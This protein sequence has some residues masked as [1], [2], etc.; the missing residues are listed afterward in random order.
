M[1]ARSSNYHITGVTVCRGLNRHPLATCGRSLRCLRAL[2]ACGLILWEDTDPFFIH[3]LKG[4]CAGL[5]RPAFPRVE[6]VTQNSCWKGESW[7]SSAL[8]SA[9][10]G[11]PVRVS[12]GVD[13]RKSGRIAAHFNCNF[14][15]LGPSEEKK[16]CEICVHFRKLKLPNLTPHRCESSV[17]ISF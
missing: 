2:V 5:P 10:G 11:I 16:C 6:L 9:T 3:A 13:P 15:T 8:L 4:A 12:L 17:L 7:M 1:T 14:F